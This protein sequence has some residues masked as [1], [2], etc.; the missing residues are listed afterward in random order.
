MTNR[1]YYS[2]EQKK[3]ELHKCISKFCNWKSLK[4]KKVVKNVIE[5]K[6]INKKLLVK[7]DI[8]ENLFQVFSSGLR[9][10]SISMFKWLNMVLMRFNFRHVEYENMKNRFLLTSGTPLPDYLIRRGILTKNACN[11]Q[12]KL[13]YGRNV[14]ITTF[15]S[16][17]YELMKNNLNFFNFYNSFI[18]NYL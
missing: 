14:Y 6:I 5:T 8:I 12:I 1:K 4:S 9:D 11:S 10:Q 2:R 7:T 18:L 15:T 3:I 13:K 17:E 16:E